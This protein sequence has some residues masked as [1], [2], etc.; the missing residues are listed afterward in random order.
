MKQDKPLGGDK[1]IQL[2]ERVKQRKLENSKEQPVGPKTD[3]GRGVP[4]QQRHAEGLRLMSEAQIIWSK[5]KNSVL[6]FF[7]SSHYH[8]TL[9]IFFQ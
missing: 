7:I 4:R 6:F 1:V 9:V 3:G 8:T 2:E 5:K